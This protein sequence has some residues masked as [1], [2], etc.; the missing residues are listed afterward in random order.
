MH[1]ALKRN[2]RIRNRRREQ[3]SQRTQQERN[4]WRYPPLLLEHILQ[5]LENGI[6]QNG[7][8]DQHQCGHN[9]RE[10]RRRPLILQQRKQRP[11]RRRGLNGLRARQRRIGDTPLPRRH[12]RIDDPDRVREQDGCGASNGACGHRL[13]HGE[14]CG[15]SGFDGRGLEARA[16]PFVPVV[17][18]EVCDADAEERRVEASVE[19]ACA[20]AVEDML[21][22]CEEGGG[23]AFGLD[24]GAG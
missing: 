13:Q 3:L 5:L 12:S 24:L 23:G 11:D 16:R 21:Y 19:P 17:V 18:D 20:F 14:L 15:L 4:K 1:P 8:D 10:Q 7:I 2:I 9:T 22:G 6:L